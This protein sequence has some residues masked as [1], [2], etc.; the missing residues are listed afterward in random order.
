MNYNIQIHYLSIKY[1][2]FMEI[3]TELEKYNLKILYNFNLKLYNEYVIKIK[4]EL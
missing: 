2:K 4:G 3:Q 1:S